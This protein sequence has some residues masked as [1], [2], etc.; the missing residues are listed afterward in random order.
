MIHRK[1]IEEI[2]EFY[3]NK[4]VEIVNEEAPNT[5]INAALYNICDAFIK[6]LQSLLDKEQVG[7]VP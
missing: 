4:Q 5:Q 2:I 1:Q 6:K 3:K 7:G